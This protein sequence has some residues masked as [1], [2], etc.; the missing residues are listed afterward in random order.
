MSGKEAFY[1]LLKRKG[2]VVDAT[3]HIVR[4][5]YASYYH[6]YRSEKTAVCGR[7]RGPHGWRLAVKRNSKQEIPTLCRDCY[8][9]N[10]LMELRFDG[11]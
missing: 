11:S 4:A 10:I 2:E 6:H 7:A 1:V 3:V 9:Q 5:P 8:E